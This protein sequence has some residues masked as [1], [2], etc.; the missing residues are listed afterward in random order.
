V[1]ALDPLRKE[2]AM[3]TL[4][5]STATTQSR[6]FF[7]LSAIDINPAK[8]SNNATTSFKRHAADYGTGTDLAPGGAL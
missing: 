8:P 7:V 5:C 4:M 1:A 3:L 2:N 6:P